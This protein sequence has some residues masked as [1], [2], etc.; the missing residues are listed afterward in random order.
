N[1]RDRNVSLRKGK[2]G[3]NHAPV[4]LH[5]DASLGPAGSRNP[6]RVR[7]NAAIAERRIRAPVGTIAGDLESDAS[8]DDDSSLS[9]QEGLNAG[10]GGYFEPASGSEPGIEVPIGRV[11]RDQDAPGTSGEGGEEGSHRHDRAALLD[12]EP[13]DATTEGPGDRG[14]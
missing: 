7:G 5:C 8:R 13:T 9:I 11:V 12:R 10:R 3:E 6:R 2:A 4:C 14:S 1:E